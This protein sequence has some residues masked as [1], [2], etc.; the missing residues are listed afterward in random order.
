MMNRFNQMDGFNANEFDDGRE[1]GIMPPGQ[2]QRITVNLE[3]A[4]LEE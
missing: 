4:V 3:D 1:M 2:T